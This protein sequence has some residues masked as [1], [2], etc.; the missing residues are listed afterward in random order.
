MNGRRAAAAAANARLAIPCRFPT[1][2]V[3]GPGRSDSMHGDVEEEQK[4]QRTRL[5]LALAG[6][7]ALMLV[8]P[9]VVRLLARH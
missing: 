6:V 5:G 4:R 9:V 7:V 1:E 2:E 8:I 3:T